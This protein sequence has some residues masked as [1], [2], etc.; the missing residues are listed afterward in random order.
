MLTSKQ[1]AADGQGVRVLQQRRE[2]ASARNAI[3]GLPF[4]QSCRSRRVG[5]EGKEEG[6]TE[7]MEGGEAADGCRQQKRSLSIARASSDAAQ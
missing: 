4:R 7:R 3:V 1:C 2:R 6:Q 5:L